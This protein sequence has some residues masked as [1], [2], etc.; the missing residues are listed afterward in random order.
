M[1]KSEI[2]SSM[3][4]PARRTA[5][6]TKL[7]DRCPACKGIKPKAKKDGTKPEPCWRCHGTRTMLETGPQRQTRRKGA[8]AFTDPEQAYV[9]GLP[10]H[11]EEVQIYRLWAMKDESMRDPLIKSLTR[12][13]KEI[14]IEEE[15]EYRAGSYKSDPTERLATIAIAE[16]EHPMQF[17]KVSTYAIFMGC[18]RRTWRVQWDKKY[19]MVYKIAEN[20]LR[21]GRMYHKTNG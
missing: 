11:I 18:N 20:W 6:E 10:K 13:V 8:P 19:R 1:A 14:A 17:T 4:T 2:K 12:L 3:P 15:W 9:P 16:I 5:A 7:L 21:Y